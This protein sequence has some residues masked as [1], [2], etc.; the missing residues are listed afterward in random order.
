M[1]NKPFSNFAGIWM[2]KCHEVFHYSCTEDT[3]VMEQIVGGYVAQRA[4]HYHLF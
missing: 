3:K 1:E 2:E 4:I